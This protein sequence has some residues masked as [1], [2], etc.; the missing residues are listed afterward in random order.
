Y[1]ASDN[2]LFYPGPP[3]VDFGGISLSTTSSG[4]FNLYYDANNPSGG[5]SWVLESVNN[6]VGYPDGQNPIDFQVSLLS[7]STPAVPEPAT[8]AMMLLGFCGLGFMAY[9]RK[10]GAGH[11]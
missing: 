9:R 6:P 2:L 5:G 1:A 3:Y 8:W 10:N 4:D 7:N 11:V